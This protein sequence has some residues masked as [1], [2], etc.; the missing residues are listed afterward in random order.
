MRAITQILR[1]QGFDTVDDAFYTQIDRWFRWYKGKVPSFHTYRQYNGLRK[2]TRERKSIGMAKKIPEDWANLALNEKVKITVSDAGLDKKL[3]EILEANNFR[4][5]ANQLIELAFALG[6][7][8]MVEYTEGDE[9][10]I[11]YIRAGMI[12]PL[13]WS[14]GEVTECAF[15]SERTTGKERRVYLNIHRLVGGNYQIENRLYKMQGNV[16]TEIDLPEGLEPVV[17]TGS[18]VPRFQLIRPNIVNNI[19]PDC[20]LGISV[21][22][23]AIDQLE[24]LDLVYDSYVN[25]FRLGKKRIVI[26]TSMARIQMQDDGI[27]QP[28]FDENDTEFYAVDL[29]DRDAPKKIEEIDMNLRHEAHEAAIKTSLG[30]LSAQCGL[31]NDRYRFERDGART[32]TEV[33]SEKSDLFQNLK[34]HEILIEKALRNLCHA[35]ASMLGS[36]TEFDVTVNFDD[37]IIEDRPAEQLRDQQQVRD[38]LMAVWEYRMKYFGEDE[39][40]AKA[41]ASELAGGQ[42]TNDE[43]M[44]FGGS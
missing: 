16:L 11:D 4:V 18:P 19:D 6:T 34:K 40:K 23:N 36:E 27:V 38:K 35:V 21:F 10:R 17:N 33:V 22:A 24:G 32:A 41:M 12:Y 26:P 39:A 30:L 7:G 37:S 44:G 28:L 31:G 5:R 13:S 15:G 42:R 29:G 1:Q 20:P 25:E 14:N 2:L 43:W 3:G 9:I 8:A